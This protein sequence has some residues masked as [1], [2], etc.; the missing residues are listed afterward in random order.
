MLL[1]FLY[2]IQNV[3]AKI[4]VYCIYRL[5]ILSNV[6][7]PCKCSVRLD[8]FQCV[9]HVNI[10]TPKPAHSHYTPLLIFS[11]SRISFYCICGGLT[12][13]R[14]LGANMR[15]LT[16]GRIAT[17]KNEVRRTKWSLASCR[18]RSEISPPILR[19]L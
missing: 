11:P 12:H 19:N 10:Y 6:F 14:Q 7:L 16:T 9:L 17:I 8:I 2:E 15:R 5:S 18:C 4:H 1:S 13:F 3:Y